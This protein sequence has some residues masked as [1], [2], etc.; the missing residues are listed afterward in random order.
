[1]NAH[2]ISVLRLLARSA[3]TVALLMVAILTPVAGQE[4]SISNDAA[5]EPG[6]RVRIEMA[7]SE[8]E[9]TLVEINSDSWRVEVDGLQREGLDVSP[10]SATRVEVS[11]GSETKILK[12]MGIGLLAGVGGGTVIGLATFEDGFFSK[13][14]QVGAAAVSLGA[15]GVVAGGII[16][17]IP[18]EQWDDVSPVPSTV[19]IL[20]RAD[21]G[22]TLSGSV[23]F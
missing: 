20:P 19:R 6:S 7:G 18:R 22:L 5:V 8:L 1:M 2:S 11:T 12:G 13:G 10:D 23:R 15:I 17:A 4:S 21:G 3:F 14:A 9:G 16:G